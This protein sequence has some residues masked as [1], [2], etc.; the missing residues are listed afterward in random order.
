MFQRETTDSDSRSQLIVIQCDSGDANGDLIACARYRIYDERVKSLEQHKDAITH[1]L[2]II[3]LPHE[4]LD[5]S[6]VGFQGDPWIS[7]HIDD[8]KPSSEATIQP[9]EAISE[10]ISKIFIGGYLEGDFIYPSSVYR[11][12]CSYLCYLCIRLVDCPVGL[13]IPNTIF[14]TSYK[15]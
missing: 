13:V 7:A 14:F 2:F 10:T 11:I 9:Q 6:F 15:W 1:V 12:Y 8:L 5:S 3:N 4:L